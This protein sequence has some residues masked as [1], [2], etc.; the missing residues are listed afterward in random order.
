MQAI[1]GYQ[2]ASTDH[3]IRLRLRQQSLHLQYWF[4]I[5]YQAKWNTVYYHNTRRKQW[6]GHCFSKNRAISIM[7]FLF[8][9]APFF[10]KAWAFFGDYAAAYASFRWLCFRLCSIFRGHLCPKKAI[11]LLHMLLFGAYAIYYA[12]IL[13]SNMLSR[14]DC[15]TAVLLYG[16]FRL[17]YSGFWW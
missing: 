12:L 4:I 10:G 2:L 15:A 16:R 13:G 5:R 1:H 3:C 11:M 8:F 6:L 14:G 17:I 9:N 7:F